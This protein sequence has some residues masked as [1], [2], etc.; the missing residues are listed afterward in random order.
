MTSI[1]SDNDSNVIFQRRHSTALV[2]ETS[3]ACYLSWSFL[4]LPCASE[5]RLFRR[6]WRRGPTLAPSIS[7]WHVLYF[8]GLAL[9]PSLLSRDR[10]W[11]QC[12][13]ARLTRLWLFEASV[14]CCLGRDGQSLVPLDVVRYLAATASKESCCETEADYVM[15]WQLSASND[16]LAVCCNCFYFYGYFSSLV[17][18]PLVRRSQWALTA[19]YLLDELRV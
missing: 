19:A 15:V 16:R 14:D 4:P 3:W 8:A 10:H 11:L 1:I 13:G 2:H 12:C 9:G 6:F 18:F 5:S 17:Y 7:S